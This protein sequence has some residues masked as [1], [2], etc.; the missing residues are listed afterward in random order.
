LSLNVADKITASLLSI[1]SGWLEPFAL[2]L[3]SLAFWDNICP[4]GTA[5]YSTR[6]PIIPSKS[7]RIHTVIHLFACPTKVPRCMCK[8]TWKNPVKQ[9]VANEYVC[10]LL[11]SFVV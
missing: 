10:E 3:L 7:E 2:G 6:L 4:E 5:P 8:L 1:E 9:S 11:L